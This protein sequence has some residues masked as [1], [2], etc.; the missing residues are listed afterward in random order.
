MLPLCLCALFVYRSTRP[1]MRLSA[2]P[3]LSFYDNNPAA[4]QETLRLERRLAN[5]YWQVAVRRIQKE[6]SPEKPLPENPPPQ[7]KVAETVR[8][9][10]SNMDSARFHYWSRLR[11]IWNERDAWVVSYGWN[12]EWVEDIVDSIP[13]YTPRWFTNIFQTFINLFNDIAQEISYH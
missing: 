7:F 4:D 6:Y 1:I 5:A 9:L 3:P 13:E 12:T 10:E 8:N 11:R 2:D